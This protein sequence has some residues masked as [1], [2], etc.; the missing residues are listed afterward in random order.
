M[1]TVH[2]HASRCL[3]SLDGDEWNIVLCAV[4]PPVRDECRPLLDGLAARHAEQDTYCKQPARHE[5]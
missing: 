5:T 2:E 4:C 3:K 1:A